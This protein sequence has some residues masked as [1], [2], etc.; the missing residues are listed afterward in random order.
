MT[1]TDIAFHY[2]P[3]LFNLLVDTIP[4]LNRSKNDVLLFFRGAG[5]PNILI[6]D[7]VQQL[8]TAPSET[9]KFEI[10]R[11]VLTRLNARGEAMLRERREVLRRVVDFTNFD[12]CWPEDQLKAKGL[13]ASIRDVV[14]QKDAFTRMNQAREQER[15]I[16]L[17]QAE[18]EKF[19]K[20]QRIANIEAAKKEL[21]GL[22][23][24]SLTPQIR[25]KKLEAAL[26]RLFQAYGIL[27]QEAFHI[28]G[29]TGE[30]I[31]EQIDG[32]VELKGTLYF[33]EMK[34]Y[35]EPVG[36]AEIAEHLVRLISR[37]ESRGLFI[38][39]SDYTEPA[40]H[41]S[42]EFLQHKIISLIHLQEIVSLL[43]RYEDLTDFFLK[44]VHAAQ[45]HKNPYFNPL[46]V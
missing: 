21:Y 3:E 41:T 25:G 4:R 42:R 2:P 27:V 30:G 7:I 14:N 11:N 29:E 34:W 6:K 28:M 45:I 16:R 46:S 40:I 24:P 1:T 17:A 32:V 8:T 12:F 38:S 35:K 20:Q 23:D 5:V 36:K 19:A 39:A 22:F 26:N 13:V 44:K 33:V 18:E 37:A 9:N 43:E 15:Q 31:V 10:T